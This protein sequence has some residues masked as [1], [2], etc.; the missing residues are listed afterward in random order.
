[1]DNKALYKDIE[2]S[3]WSDRSGLTESERILID[4]YLAADLPTLEAGTAGG[5]ILFGMLDLG[6]TKLHGFDYVEEFI[7]SARQRD[8]DQAIDFRVQDAQNLDYQDNSFDQIL[9]L[10]QIM[11]A[12]ESAPARESA[13]KEA[14]RILRPGGT[15]LFSFLDLQ[16]RISRAPFSIYYWYLRAAR[17]LSRRKIPINNWPWLKLNQRFNWSSLLDRPPYNYWFSREEPIRLLENAG[18]HIEQYGSDAQILTRQELPPRNE[19]PKDSEFSG[20]TYAVCTK[21]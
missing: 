20:M 21:K 11:S 16:Y 13:A 3:A 6:F 10:Q 9:Y 4:R 5:R 2:F 18:F 19:P 12:I 17:T 1:M 7:Q 14:F 8:I 15:A